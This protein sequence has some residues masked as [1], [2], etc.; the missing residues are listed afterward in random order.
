MATRVMA[1]TRGSTSRWIGS[2]PSTLRASISSR[3]TREPRSAAMAVAPAPETTRTAAIGDAVVMATRPAAAPARSSAPISPRS[4]YTRKSTTPEVG[5]H[6][7]Q[8]GHDRDAQDELGLLNELA[9]AERP[10]CHRHSGVEGSCEEPAQRPNR[11][12]NGSPQSHRRLLLRSS[13]EAP[14]QHNFVTCKSF[15][16]PRNVTQSTLFRNEATA[17]TRRAPERRQESQNGRDTLAQPPKEHP[18]ATT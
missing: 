13:I 1:S 3:M 12:L 6:Q 4:W 11:G 10:A 14:R 16:T 7:Q 17:F 15:L 18:N 5:D 2:M 9:V 8:R